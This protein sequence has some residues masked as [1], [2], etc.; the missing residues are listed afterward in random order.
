M[1]SRDTPAGSPR[2]NAGGAIFVVVLLAV[3]GTA[4]VATAA[5]TRPAAPPG[6][7][8]SSVAGGPSSAGVAAPSS[9]GPGITVAT[10]V[11][12][13]DSL[14]A[15]NQLTGSIGLIAS[16][17]ALDSGDQRL[18]VGNAGD[19][20]NNSQ[21]V[22]KLFAVSTANRSISGT[23]S[24]GGEQNALALDSPDHQL[25]AADGTGPGNVSVVDTTLGSV[26]YAL[27]VGNYPSGLA[28]D[29][30]SDLLFVANVG[31]GN[32]TV[33]NATVGLVVD[34]ISGA[35]G[36]IAFDPATKDVYA[37]SELSNQIIAINGSLGNNGSGV[38]TA[39]G[40]GSVA[41]TAD[42]VNGDLWIAK[43]SGNVSV[44]DPR[45]N[46]V[47][48]VINNGVYPSAIAYDPGN[49][50]IY[51]A[52]GLGSGPGNLT[53]LNGTTGAV[54]GSVSV[55]I[56]PT[57]IAVDAAN[58]TLYVS[59][60]PEGTISI[61]DT[62][63][64]LNYL[65]AVSLAPKD[66]N[67]AA[68]SAVTVD[69]SP[70]CDAGACPSNVTF[71]WTASNSLGSLNSSTTSS[72]RFTA[73][74]TVGNTT[75]TVTA[76]LNGT[77]VQGSARINI[78]SPLVGVS[79]NPVAASV[80]TGRSVSL[81]ATASCG[82]PGCPTSPAFTWSVPG[83]L[84]TLNTTSGSS[85]RF[86]AG[87]TT[88]GTKVSVRASLYGVS[89][90]AF[91]RIN[92]TASNFTAILSQSAASGPGPLTV[93]FNGSANGTSG[94]YSFSWT[95]GDGSSGS[96]ASVSHTYTATGVYPVVLV[97]SDSLNESIHLTASVQVYPPSSG[98]PGQGNTHWGGPLYVSISGDP[99]T[100]AA[101]LTTELAAGASGGVPPYSF[102]WNFGDGSS[103]ASGASV[104]HSFARSGEFA[105]TVFVS[106]AAGDQAET[107]VFVAVGNGSAGGPASLAVYVTV[108]EFQGTAPFTAQFSPAAIGGSGV[109]SLAWN[110]GDGSSPL[111]TAGLA[112][113][114]HTYT[115]GGHFFPSLTI[116][117]SAGHT[118]GWSSE[119]LGHPVSVT[120]SSPV[121]SGPAAFGL[122]L[123]WVAALVVGA[124]IAGAAVGGLSRSRREETAHAEPVR[125]GYEAYRRPATPTPPPAPAT[126]AKSTTPPADDPEGDML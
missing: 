98:G 85:V 49:G 10:L 122:P 59:N 8:P 65:T 76:S 115:T 121:S 26:T 54:V 15:G 39:N 16:S 66:S 32:V 62:S 84:G 112:A 46:T 105:A 51:E 100:G 72:V 35:G 17:V 96:G 73:G 126:R 57:A 92:I 44:I 106:D 13:N 52:G 37:V 21:Y 123:I 24:V 113:V 102:E 80:T 9:A 22:G 90:S 20:A 116:S 75:L 97:T 71:A 14:E 79:V 5:V 117:D 27:D 31:S 118:A 124:L 77:S 67:V 69:A 120:G 42:P 108:L 63:P 23:I 11:L 107:G 28:L 64:S 93:W 60:G 109:Y 91:A 78:T 45:N 4:V 48:R 89:L 12:W 88:G 104:G 103:N 18:Y 29:P 38:L 43:T 68:T 110:F 82:A 47:V 114:S 87:N 7:I 1:T 58:E 111:T 33:I 19:G 34:N 40:Q 101:P 125:A 25:F 50:Y 3:A 95:F 94:P 74:T 41:I 119:L 83:A 61:V 56:Q 81:T 30:R 6:G 70:V 53:V 55:G 86:T 2:W 36:A 99:V